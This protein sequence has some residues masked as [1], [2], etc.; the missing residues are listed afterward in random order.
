MNLLITGVSGFLGQAVVARLLQENPF[1]KIIGVDTH[2]P[3]IL[4]PVEFI[5]A[6]IRSVDLGDLMVMNHIQALLHLQY[7]TND[8][9]RSPAEEVR[10]AEQLF[11]LAELVGL[12]RVIFASRDWIYASLEGDSG[13]DA[14]LLDPTAVNQPEVS[15]KLS[16]ERTARAFMERSVGVEV[17]M[18]RTCHI[19]GPDRKTP[20]DAVLELPWILGPEQADPK[21]HLLHVDDAAAIF[22]K[23]AALEGFSGPVN[24]AGLE[25]ITLSVLAGI[26]QKKLKRPP[27]W[28]VQALTDALSRMKLVKF[29]RHALQQLHH[30]V[31]VRTARMIN[32]LGVTPRYSTRQTLAVWR[33]RYQE[34]RGQRLR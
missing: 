15:A 14:P 26:L 3:E 12:K 33:A 5:A 22:L 30:G 32:E 31:G 11:E 1:G 34:T 24:A 23:A 8:G 9:Q 19:L 29:N 28:M 6:D 21:V 20:L 25:P 2:A 16:I 13:E 10:V 7:A 27:I 17:V 4:G 18:V